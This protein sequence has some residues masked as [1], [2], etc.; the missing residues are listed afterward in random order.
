MS[1]EQSGCLFTSEC[2]DFSVVLGL[3]QNELDND[4]KIFPIT[5]KGTINL[6]F[7][8]KVESICHVRVYDL[9]GNTLFENSYVESNATIDLNHL[10]EGFYFFEITKDNVQLIK[11]IIK[12]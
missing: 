2:V 1:I 9:R 5:S 11:R 8:S 4:I 7:N 10:G 12:K 3:I 6:L